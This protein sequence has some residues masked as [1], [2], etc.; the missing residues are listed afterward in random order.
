M[1]IR[2][3]CL[4]R[5][6]VPTPGATVVITI[7]IAVVLLVPVAFG[8]SVPNPSL[9]G[10]ISVTAIPGS[11]LRNYTFFSSNHDLATHGYVE[12]E[13]FFSG[14]ANRYNAPPLATGT[15]IDS[16]HPYI[17]RLVVRR[18]A[19]PRDF[20]GTVLVEWYNV[21]NGFDGDNVWFFSWEQIM[22]AGYAWVGV[23]TQQV[24]VNALK[25]W[26]PSRYGTLDVTQGGTITDDSLSYDIFSQAGQAI[27]DLLQPRVMLATGHSMSSFRLAVYANSIQPLTNEYD[28]ILLL[29][30]SVLT[31][32]Q[33]RKDLTVPVWKILTEYDVA[34]NEALLRQP[35]T[36]MFRT[37]EVAGTSHIN[38][39]FRASREPLELRDNGT[40]LEAVLAP[41]CANPTLGTRVPTTY[42]LASAY[43]LFA[44]WVR[45][46]VPPPTAP[47]IQIATF[48]SPG[49]N[50]V[51]ARNSLGLA[52]GGIQL[53]QVAVPT[54]LNYG[55]NSGPGRCDSWGYYSPFDIEEL[56]QLYPTHNGYVNQVSEVANEN[57]RAGYILDT[58]A[59]QTI[60]CAVYSN[61]GGSGNDEEEEEKRGYFHMGRSG[62]DGEERRSLATFSCNPYF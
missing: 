31:T 23:S 36:N 8:A 58:D 52:L 29:S 20:N 14:T 39:Y 4:S 18:P 24:G 2:T 34:I 57:V 49:V 16:G 44:R 45:D 47:R 37:W 13:Y 27:R 50:S 3:R 7:V 40:S 11:P 32:F 33:I 17:T 28:G 12:E 62:N 25:A 53:A 55:V 51:I 15:V 26:S 46:G 38:Q 41:Q 30:T 43:D 22:R 35:D 42:V 9:I 6:P 1:K 19:N 61:V 60:L 59:Q 21:S 56:G 10:P 54:A 48:G 5:M